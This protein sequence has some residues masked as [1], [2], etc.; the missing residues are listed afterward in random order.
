MKSKVSVPSLV[1]QEVTSSEK[2]QYNERVII[3]GRWDVPLR[4]CA[5]SNFCAGLQEEN[6]IYE[7][8]DR[9]ESVFPLDDIPDIS[10]E[11]ESINKLMNFSEVAFNNVFG[12]RL[13]YAAYFG[14]SYSSMD[15]L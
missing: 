14:M 10:Q 2:S 1:R 7:E 6:W 5:V 9:G 15:S 11:I 13:E 8:M 12:K 4:N 3:P